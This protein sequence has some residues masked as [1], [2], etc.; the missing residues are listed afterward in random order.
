M[1]KYILSAIAGAIAFG[2][3]AVLLVGIMELGFMAFGP[4]GSLV[5]VIALAGACIGL[6]AAMDANDS[7][8]D[9]ECPTCR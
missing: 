4:I 7:D 8:D 9:E 1:I 5:G 3:F 2:I 6:A